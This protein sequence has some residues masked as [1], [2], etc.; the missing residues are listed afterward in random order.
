M[1]KP[2]SP[3]IYSLRQ[4]VPFTFS[5]GLTD[6]TTYV[7]LALGQV[8][9]G[10]TLYVP[11]GRYLITGVTRHWPITIF[12]PGVFVVDVNDYGFNCNPGAVSGLDSATGA[13]A[14]GDLISITSISDYNLTS[15]SNGPK[16][17]SIVCSTDHE[18]EQ[19]DVV[20]F[21][22]DLKYGLITDDWI[23][24]IAR[25]IKVPSSTSF[26]TDHKLEDIPAGSGATKHFRQLPRGVWDLQLNFDAPSGG[27][28][29]SRTNNEPL[30]ELLGA[31]QPTIK[32]RVEKS[33]GRG[34]QIH[35]VY[36]GLIE[37]IFR[38][39]DDAD[40]TT[41]NP[42]NELGYGV[43]VGGGTCGTRVSVRAGGC[44]HGFTT[45][46]YTASGSYLTSLNPTTRFQDVGAS[47]D[48]VVHD[49][50]IIGSYLASYDTHALAKRI[51][52]DNCLAAFPS[53]RMETATGLSVGFQ[54]RSLNTTFNN[55]VVTGARIGWEILAGNFWAGRTTLNGCRD[56]GTTDRSIKCTL[57][58]PVGTPMLIVGNH[59]SN[60]TVGSFLEAT[61]ARVIL[62]NYLC[63]S[64]AA[65][66]SNAFLLNNGVTLFIMGCIHLA[67]TGTPTV[68]KTQ[69]SATSSLVLKGYHLT[70]NNSDSPK[71]PFALL[72]TNSGTTMN[73]QVDDCSF[74]PGL[75][76]VQGI[77]STT[78]PGT[79]TLQ[80]D[81]WKQLGRRHEFGTVAPTSGA[82]RV[83]DIAWHSA[84]AASGNIGWVCTTAGTPGTWKTFGTISS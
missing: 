10:G 45:E 76:P 61:S 50:V 49:S 26:V 73:V 40:N 52:F 18:L 30:I 19:G 43:V 64:T 27:E 38:E 68:F 5:D 44:R 20:K 14:W 72:T 59:S 78:N 41:S 36:G 1:T 13:A 46:D 31:I 29:T 9:I 57:S 80:G 63:E 70:Q 54:D 58:T 53:N 67:G 51:S 47:R 84:P 77:V 34:V 74:D 55:C 8:P 69:N 11:E 3:R 25:V 48:V 60:V 17:S 37:C 39:M 83:G 65:G 23:G 71:T 4:W 28:S 79:L 22:A 12:G 75:F 56:D 21:T 2:Q 82:H 6:V 32:C 81:G 15:S 35:S 16:A 7:Q 42:L 33:Y 24:E 66:S 62:R